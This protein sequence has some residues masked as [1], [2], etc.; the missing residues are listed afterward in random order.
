MRITPVFIDLHWLPIKARII[1]KICVLTY[2]AMNTGKPEYIRDQ[3]QR[4][5]CNANVAVRHAYDE[6]TS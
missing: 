3:L 2:Q 6:Q 1:F 4:F 5:E